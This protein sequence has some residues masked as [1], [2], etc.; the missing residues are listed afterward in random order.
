MLVRLKV[1]CRSK[2]TVFIPMKTSSHTP[3][4]IRSSATSKL[5]VVINFRSIGNL[6]SK[7]KAWTSRSHDGLPVFLICDYIGDAGRIFIGARITL[8]SSAD[9]Y[10]SLPSEWL[11]ACQANRCKF[12]WKLRNS[13]LRLSNFPVTETFQGTGTIYIGYE[14]VVPIRFQTQEVWRLKRCL[15]FNQARL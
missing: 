7:S 1:P 13:H 3:M 14:R 11:S 6:P 5:W 4:I 12:H 15:D 9:F 2:N 10:E 8:F